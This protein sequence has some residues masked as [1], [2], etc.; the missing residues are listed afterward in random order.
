MDDKEILQNSK[1]LSLDYLKKIGAEVEE[2]HGLYSITIPDGFEPIF[3]T[4]SKR[5]T[6]DHEIAET[7]SC[8]LVVPG[9]NFL[10][11]IL[12]QIKKQAPVIGAHLQKQ[13]EN[14]QEAVGSISTHNCEIN[15]I[16]SKEEINIAIRYFF[17]I[18]VKS[19]KRVAMLRWV[20]VDLET[21]EI[22][23]FPSEI[24][25]DESL[26]E[27]KYGQGDSRIDYA[28]SKATEFLNDEIQHLALKY[29]DLTKNNQTRDINSVIQA[30]ERRIKEFNQDV[31]LQKNKLHEYDRKMTNARSYETQIKYAEQKNK[32]EGRIEKEQE[33][34]GKLIQRL[35]KDKTIQIEQIEKRYRPI[36]DFSLV[37][38]KVYSYSVTDCNL[39]FKNKVSNKQ[40]HVKYIDPS[41][42]FIVNCEIC[43]N[44]IEKVHLCINSHL[45]CDFCTTH[46]VKCEKDVC[47][48]CTN[49]LNPC[50]ICQE[51]LCS[52]CTAKCNFCSEL[53]CENHMMR[54]PHCSQKTC[55]FC[56]DDCQICF[57]R[58]CE[59]SL[60]SC[61]KCKKRLCKV[62]SIKCVECKSQ[63][64]SND[65]SICG[66][67]EK[68]HCLQDSRKC[69]LC[70]QFYN[71]S[72]ASGK[73]CDTCKKL[74]PVEKE[75]Q[76]VQDII[77]VYKELEKIKKWECSANKK[78]SVFKIKKLLRSKIIVYDK[79]KKEVVIHKKGGWR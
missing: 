47:T 34:L 56:S 57:K 15:C 66:I 60:S 38:A 45:G 16:D 23:E 53:T 62:D 74:Q 5:I 6:F 40:T 26:G 31:N 79:I 52:D 35:V 2:S 64:C 70:E 77:L 22:L 43:K 49:E 44:D 78:F 73:Q 68:N 9:S 12:N 8:E 42:K 28:Y 71:N 58:F 72:C 32:Q 20:D 63:F 39:E 1:E 41:K 33:K 69:E 36:V 55:Y 37:A 50:Y 4:I 75:H 21:L 76:E 61:N 17:N 10:G 65:V 14:P 48:S 24:M 67:C 27:I 46:C 7:H 3:G 18:N 30:H 13:I 19:I 11:I 54:C 29:S 59:E 25:V 51:G